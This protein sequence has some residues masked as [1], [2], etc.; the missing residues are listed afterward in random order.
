MSIFLTTDT[1][2]GHQKMEEYCGRPRGFEFLIYNSF[3]CLTD[4]DLLVHL[5]DVCIE[6][7]EKWHLMF[8]QTLQCKKIL[9]RGNHDKKSNGWYSRHGWDFVCES[10]SDTLFKKRILFSHTPSRDDG[11]FDINIHGHFHNNLERLKRKEWVTEG[12]EERNKHDLANLTEKHKLISLEMNNYQL[13]KLESL[14]LKNPPQ[15]S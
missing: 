1:H 12:E 9:I 11:S 14:C 7:D 6:N 8:I 2:F 15:A 13:T 10:F 4:Q 5:G 3:K